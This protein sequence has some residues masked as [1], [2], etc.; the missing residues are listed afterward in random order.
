MSFAFTEHIFFTRTT[1]NRSKKKANSDSS[2]SQGSRRTRLGESVAKEETWTRR[3]YFSP[4]GRVALVFLILNTGLYAPKLMEQL[5]ANIRYQIFCDVRISTKNPLIN[6]KLI[7]EMILD[8]S[9]RLR[10]QTN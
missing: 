8:L 7:D 1:R 10:I 9:Q 3:V 2:A 6:H 4:K 5:N